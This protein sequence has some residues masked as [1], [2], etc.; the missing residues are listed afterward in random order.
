L[1]YATLLIM[2][3]YLSS[4]RL[5]LPAFWDEPKV[6]F[7][8]LLRMLESLGNYFRDQATPFDRPPGLH[9]LYLPFLYLFGYQIWLIRCLNLIYFFSGTVLLHRSLRTAGEWPALLT[10]ATFLSTPIVLVYST[11][12]VAD[13]QL[14]FI[15]SLF[16]YLLK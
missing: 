1:V 16:L 8:P 13:P 6:Y 9:L 3:L 10:L 5:G 14:F 12:Y 11:Q 7:R 15:C 4:G 2:F